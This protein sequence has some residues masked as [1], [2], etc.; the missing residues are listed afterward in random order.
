ME[1]FISKFLNV[2]RIFVLFFFKFVEKFEFLIM[3]YFEFLVLKKNK[4]YYLKSECFG[5]LF[6]FF[7]IGLLFLFF[8]FLFSVFIFVYF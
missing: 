1:F 2:S 8:S 7:L 3:I 6:Y 4:V 5:V